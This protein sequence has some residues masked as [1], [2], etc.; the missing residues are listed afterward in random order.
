MIIN[1]ERAPMLTAV[2]QIATALA[3]L[4]GK[5][6]DGGDCRGKVDGSTATGCHPGC[7][8]G[9]VSFDKLWR[10]FKSGATGYIPG[11]GLV[12]SGTL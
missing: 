7:H 11:W 12:V 3:K 4:A 6:L 5:F 10:R 9:G 1:P 2:L 8:P